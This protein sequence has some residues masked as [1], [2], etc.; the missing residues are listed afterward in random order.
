MLANR[1]FACALTAAL[2]ACA[3]PTE[4]PT[5]EL[6]TALVAADTRFE[7]VPQLPT[8]ARA[9][10]LE[11]AEKMPYYPANVAP[12]GAHEGPIAGFDET[13]DDHAAVALPET[14]RP[15][16]PD[17]EIELAIE[18]TFA[19]NVPTMVKLSGRTPLT[20]IGDPCKTYCKH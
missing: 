3:Y 11:Q 18:H 1:I 19:I 6:S 10:E 20:R 14:P 7:Q 15:L 4:S 2:G 8:F 13:A 5:E 16:D 17:M 12:I 9:P